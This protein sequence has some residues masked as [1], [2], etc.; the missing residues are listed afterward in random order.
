M[1]VSVTEIA[2][3]TPFGNFHDRPV[4]RLIDQQRVAVRCGGRRFRWNPAQQRKHHQRRS[5]KPFH[6]NSPSVLDQSLWSSSRRKR[7]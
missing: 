6:G 7:W 3:T 5:Q 2:S 1:A 4:F